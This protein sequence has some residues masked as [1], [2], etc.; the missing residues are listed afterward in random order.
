MTDGRALFVFYGQ[1]VSTADYLSDFRL[2]GGRIDHNDFYQWTDITNFLISRVCN[3]LCCIAFD[4]I[5]TCASPALLLQLIK[6]FHQNSPAVGHFLHHAFLL[7]GQAAYIQYMKLLLVAENK[8]RCSFSS[9]KC[10]FYTRTLMCSYSLVSNRHRLRVSGR[11]NEAHGRGVQFASSCILHV[12]S[13]PIV[14]EK[15]VPLPTQDRPLYTFNSY[16]LSSA[17]EPQSEVSLTQCNQLDPERLWV[18]KGS[19]LLNF[20]WTMFSHNNLYF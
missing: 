11:D 4:L 8:T 13:G 19:V 10:S 2:L 5:C 9:L 6:A 1:E 14:P 15:S 3:V 17:I 7:A 16:N 18:L 12:P 20:T